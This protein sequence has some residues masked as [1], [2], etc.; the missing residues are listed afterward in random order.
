M[1]RKPSYQSIGVRLTTLIVACCGM[2]S[3]RAEG[4]LLPS[5]RREK[6]FG[7]QQMGWPQPDSSHDGQAAAVCAT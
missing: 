5:R 6:D 4:S 2:S 3:V 7:A 1:R